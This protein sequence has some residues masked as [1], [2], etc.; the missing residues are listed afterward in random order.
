MMIATTMATMVAVLKR[1]YYVPPFVLVRS[2]H[3][4]FL[5]SWLDFEQDM[6]LKKS[7]SVGRLRSQ[8]FRKHVASGFIW[9]VL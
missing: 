7:A 4:P 5:T 9:V 6:S 3:Y 1:G 2:L 8:A